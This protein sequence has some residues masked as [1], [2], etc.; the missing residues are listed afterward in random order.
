VPE[1]PPA[2]QHELPTAA[3]GR[4]SPRSA[5]IVDMQRSRLA[6]LADAVIEADAGRAALSGQ[7]RDEPAA[8]EE[9]APLD[10]MIWAVTN[11]TRETLSFLRGLTEYNLAVADYALAALPA[12][13]TPDE[14]A[15]R[16][17]IIAVDTSG[18]S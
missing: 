17:L 14:L 13:I 18:G 7:R 6:D 9:S 5:E 3:A 15:K 4:A 11:Q 16:L 1:T 12:T 2:S 10:D 8:S